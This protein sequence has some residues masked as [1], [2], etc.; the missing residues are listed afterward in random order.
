MV[1]GRWVA[2][3]LLPV[4]F[5]GKERSLDKQ[6]EAGVRV[7]PRPPRHKLP[8]G[9]WQTWR[10]WNFSTTELTASPNSPVWEMGALRSKTF[11]FSRISMRLSHRWHSAATEPAIKH[12]TIQAVCLV[13]LRA[14]ALGAIWLPPESGR[15]L[16]PSL[17]GH[18]PD[19]LGG[20]P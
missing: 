15:H 7:V 1:G 17:W 20:W 10:T 4:S 13:A 8:E 12:P 16:H 3:L 2:L 9:S 14:K 6:E 18:L 5:L 11:S 19:R